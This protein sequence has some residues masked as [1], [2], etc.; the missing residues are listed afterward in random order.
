MANRKISYTDRDFEGL[1]QDLIDYTQQYYPDLIQNFNDA[2][3]FSVLMDL[4]AAIGDNLNYHIDRSVQETVLQ[5]AQ[6]RSSIFN[7]ART[8]GLKIPG[9]RPSVA[10]IDISITVPAYGDAED[11]RYLGILRSG[12]QFNGGGTTFETV[13][14]IDFSSQFNREGF[15]NRTKIPQFSENNSA[16][17]SYI[18]TKREIVVNGSTQVFK[19]VVT[20]ADVSPFFNFFLPEKNVLGVTSIIQKDGTNYQATPS[21]TEFE[22]STDKWYEVDALVE[23]TVFIEDPTKPV[24]EA[25]VKVGRYLKTENR[26]IT[27]YTPEGFLKIQFGAGTVTPEDQ[28][29]QFTTVGV[30]LK[31]QNYQNNIGLGLTVSPNT[32]LFVQYRTGGGLGSNVGVGA[33]NQV[34]TIDFAV[35]GPS[36]IINNNVT[37]SMR[38]NNVTAAIGGA[39]QPSVEEVRNMVTF[40]FAAQKRAV[41]INDYK[42]LIDNMPGRFGAPSKVSI[43]EFNNKILVKIL[44]FDTEGALTQTV[45]N[46]LKTNLATY[47]SKYRMIND[48]ISIEVA[49]VIDL[50]FEFFIVLNS[51]GSQSQVITEVI[52]NVTNYMLPSTRELGENVN[53][54]EIRQLIQNINGVNTLSE[55]R[56]Y[57]KVGGV[58]SSSETSQ[59]YV[60]TT[61][62]Q[63]ELIDDTIFAEPDQIY[64]IRYPAKDIKVRVKNLTSVDFS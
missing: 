64:Q 3:V 12:A 39:N 48:Y 63:I 51:T 49:K 7:I 62:K 55:I 10:V 47:L 26:F 14:D 25:G 2:S 31:L 43:T 33:I 34:G 6:Q 60:D 54:S 42:S 4:N 20:S 56:V 44:S 46:N 28:L 41:T 19:K 61:T 37:Q 27:E 5:Y 38:V 22:T 50:E 1:R 8:Y 58:Y 45:S 40:N 9:Y 29:R 13:Y 57:N 59:R 36:D 17:T 30:P 32:T 21:F 18:I 15:I 16:P 53:V 35:N 24:D 23:N 11:T 52:N